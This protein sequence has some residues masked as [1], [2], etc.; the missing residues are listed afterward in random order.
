MITVFLKGA[1]I[2]SESRIEPLY[3]TR[4]ISSEPLR[5]IRRLAWPLEIA[6]GVLAGF[7]TLLLVA[8]LVM[9]YVPGNY[10]T[11]NAS[12]GWLTLDPS[13][14]PPDAVTVP[15]LPIVT[16]LCGLVAGLAISGS[17]ILALVS[18]HRLFGLYRC[19]IVFSSAAIGCM[20]RA[21]YGF[22]L[23]GVL[24]GALQP[25]MRAIGSPDRN[26]FHAETIPL[27]LIGSGL[28]VFSQIIALGVDLQRENKGFV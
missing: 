25:F 1:V 4:P 21:G 11:F 2:M 22:L 14:A 19:G 17:L 12:G 28:V 9:A 8:V 3:P 26:W 6:F 7:A 23:F 18:L 27:L 16:Q 10:V 24:P 5:R 13:N 15:S 20:R